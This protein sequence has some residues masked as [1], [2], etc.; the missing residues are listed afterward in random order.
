M[1]DAGNKKHSDELG[2][3][4]HVEYKRLGRRKVRSFTLPQFK[5]LLLSFY[6][7]TLE[8]FVFGD[9]EK[10]DGTFWESSN[11]SLD[12]WA[13]HHKL[14]EFEVSVIFRANDNIHSYS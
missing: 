14:T 12:A 4:V 10:P 5:N 9:L 11:A 7:F 6:D 3:A 2:P 8:P 13:A 1:T